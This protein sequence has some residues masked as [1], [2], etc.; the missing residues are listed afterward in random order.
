MWIDPTA[1]GHGW[2][3]DA[4]PDDDVEFRAHGAEGALSATPSSAASG[5]MDLLSVVTHELGHALGLDSHALLSSTL[6]TGLRVMPDDSGPADRPSI[7]RTAYEY[8]VRVL[9][10]EGL[11]D[12]EDDDTWD[13]AIREISFDS[14]RASA[15]AAN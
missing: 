11:P 2:F 8:A 4:T 15:P 5:A 9:A 3:V 14:E 6:D 10:A 12:D 13:F 1:A 7:D